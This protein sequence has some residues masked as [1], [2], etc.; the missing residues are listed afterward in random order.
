MAKRVSVPLSVEEYKA[1]AQKTIIVDTRKDVGAG[2]IKGA[3]WLPS[4]GAIVYWLTSLVP[5]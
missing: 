1:L 4:K 3:Y 2:L 5:P